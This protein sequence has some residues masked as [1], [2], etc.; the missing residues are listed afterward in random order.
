MD[1]KKDIS[2]GIYF[3]RK[4]FLSSAYQALNKVGRMFL[5][6][7]L[8]ARQTN[9]A[10][11]KQVKKGFRTDRFID[12]DKIKM[13]YSKLIETF[14]IPIGSIPRGI[15]DCLA[16]GFIEIKHQGG[17]G[18]H[19]QTVYAL[20]ED[21]LEWTKGKVFRQ[22]QSE[23]RGFQGK[24]LGATALKCTKCGGP[25]DSVTNKKI[26]ARKMSDLYARKMSDFLQSK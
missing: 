4:M 26:V 12:L 15:D 22:R 8:D 24:R 19:D 16:K 5:L 25:M 1:A 13:P 21:Y 2:G 23:K 9:P 6:A 18:E 11:K 10:F 14:G 7:L 3:E 20:I 17:S